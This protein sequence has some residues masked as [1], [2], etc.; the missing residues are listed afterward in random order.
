MRTIPHWTDFWRVQI[1]SKKIIFLD[2]DGTL[3]E[4]GSNEPPASALE[5]I[6]SARKA[7]NL[8]FLCSGRNYGMLSPLLKYGFDGAVA[9]A[10]GYIVC[11]DQVIYDCPMTEEQ[12]IKVMKILKE[13]GVFRT[14]E[15]VDGAYADECLENFL[16]E[17]FGKNGSS[18]LLRWREMIKKSFH[19]RP[20]KE[21]AGQPVYKFVVMSPSMDN[22]NQS[23][24]VLEKEFQF[25]IQDDSRGFVNCEIINRNFNKGMGVKRVCEYYQIPISDSVGFG[26]SMNDKEMLETVGLSI[27]M[28]NGSEAVKKIAD[29][30]CPPVTED[31]L[32]KSFQKHHLM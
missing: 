19:I 21:Y 31:G 29:E 11:G 9:S 30:I 3:T 23:K 24:T 16:K 27:C 18:E 5:A 7:G 2:I 15:C 4:P 20:M 28:E 25:C 22:L 10:G 13:N 14:A 32:W 1:M 6:K 8:V 17:S 12:K 26:D